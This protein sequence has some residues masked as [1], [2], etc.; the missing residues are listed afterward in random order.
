MVVAWPTAGDGAI[1][2]TGVYGHQG[3]DN[4]GRDEF[5]RDGHNHGLTG[6][7]AMYHAEW[8]G[9]DP[10]DVEPVMVYESE[11]FDPTSELDVNGWWPDDEFAFCEVQNEAHALAEVPRVA[12]AAHDFARALRSGK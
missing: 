4:F 6:F 10:Q 12:V 7:F 5:D 1:V 3:C 8:F 2:I 9:E 11:G